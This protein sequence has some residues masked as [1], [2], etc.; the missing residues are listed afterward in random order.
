MITVYIVSFFVLL[1]VVF[2]LRPKKSTTIDDV[3]AQAKDRSQQRKMD[4][5]FANT[6]PAQDPYD[7]VY[8]LSLAMSAV[9]VDESANGYGMLDDEQRRVIAAIF[10]SQ[11][12]TPSSLSAARVIRGA[13]W[14]HSVFG[15]DNKVEGVQSKTA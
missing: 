3:V 12:Q 14:T 10:D 4:R 8:E 7:R 1:A 2:L 11:S 13:R 6:E 5:E 9:E 15:E